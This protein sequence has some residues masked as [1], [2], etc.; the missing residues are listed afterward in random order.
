MFTFLHAQLWFEMS[1]LS[2][3]RFSALSQ[4]V[5]EV[6][7]GIQLG[8]PQLTYTRD[9]DLYPVY[10][11][12]PAEPFVFSVFLFCFVGGDLTDFHTG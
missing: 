2:T 6:M 12:L 5:T 7:E 4:I 10:Q 8:L 1:Y 9:S 11:L 3:D